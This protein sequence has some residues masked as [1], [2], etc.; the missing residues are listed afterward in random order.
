MINQDRVY[1]I[2]IQCNDLLPFVESIP[3]LGDCPADQL[4]FWIGLFWLG[5]T[6]DRISR[7]HNITVGDYL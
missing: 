6:D 7:H 2:D 3:G 1:Y 4:A 5:D